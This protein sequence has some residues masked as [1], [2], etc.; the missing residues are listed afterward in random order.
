MEMVRALSESNSAVLARRRC[1][2]CSPSHSG[3]T[4]N[5]TITIARADGE[6]IEDEENKWKELGLQ[7]AG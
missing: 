2:L 5:L 6:D 7:N 3:L 1:S 4:I